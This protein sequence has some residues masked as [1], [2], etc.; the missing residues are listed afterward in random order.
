MTDTERRRPRI[1]HRDDPAAPATDLD[2]ISYL[3]FN[4]ADRIDALKEKILTSEK[5]LFDLDTAVMMLEGNPGN[6]ADHVEATDEP[7]KGQKRN[8]DFNPR[9]PCT[10]CELKRTESAREYVKYGVAQLRALYSRMLNS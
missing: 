10:R 3:S 7:E 8:R 5:Q 6:G 9:C 2:E 4:T 1:V